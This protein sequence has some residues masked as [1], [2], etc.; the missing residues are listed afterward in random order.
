MRKL[1]WFV[2][3]S[4]SLLLMVPT[5]VP[6]QSLLVSDIDDTIR[7]MNTQS[8][9][10]MVLRGRKK[11]NDF[12][13]VK[14]LYEEWRRQSSQNHIAFVTAGPRIFAKFYQRF[15]NFTGFQFDF[16]AM[17]PKKTDTFSHKVQ[18]LRSLYGQVQPSATILVGDN[19]ALDP[20]V[21][22][23]TQSD[24][25][26]TPTSIYI[27]QLYSGPKARPLRQ[28]QVAWLT[29]A[30]LAVHMF[31]RQQISE[32]SLRRVLGVVETDLVYRPKKVIARFFDCSDFYRHTA[33]P[34]FQVPVDAQLIERLDR[35]GQSVGGLCDRF[36]ASDAD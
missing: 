27:H 31:H 20:D 8:P 29:A 9:V 24:F 7:A 3:I 17:R 28:G 5:S 32:D 34:Q 1:V 35:I 6:A 16:L 26:Q 13:G 2:S 12:S 25:P 11:D 19:S 14:A 15:L 36:S 18:S 4:F 33:W 10:G 22:A 30:D 23:Q 21:Y